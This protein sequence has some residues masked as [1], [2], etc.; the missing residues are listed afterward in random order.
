MF[1]LSILTFQRDRHYE[2]ASALGLL[3]LMAAVLILPAG[4]ALAL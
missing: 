3:V 1:T 4:G 2:P